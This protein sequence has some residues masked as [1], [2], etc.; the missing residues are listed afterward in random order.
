MVAPDSCFCERIDKKLD[1]SINLLH[2]MP[3]T[4]PLE[5]ARENRI[6]LKRIKNVY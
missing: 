2:N 4:T 5:V 6:T 1:F 3:R